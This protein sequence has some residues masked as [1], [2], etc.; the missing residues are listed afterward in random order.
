MTRF[1][2]CAV[3]FRTTPNNRNSR[4]DSL[5]NERASSTDS[6]DLSEWRVQYSARDSTELRTGCWMATS[7]YLGTG[8]IL[9]IIPATSSAHHA[10]LRYPSDISLHCLIQSRGC[11]LA[12]WV[13]TVLRVQSNRVADQARVWGPA[14]TLLNDSCVPGACRPLSRNRIP[15]ITKIF[16]DLPPGTARNIVTA[17]HP[18]IIGMSGPVFRRLHGATTSVPRPT[19]RLGDP[20]RISPGVPTVP[21]QQ[22]IEASA[23]RHNQRVMSK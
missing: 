14:Q 18:R 7:R 17:P 12:T 3:L 4:S 6:C 22:Q 19:S 13:V 5:A 9:T 21:G 15:R 20:T 16:V 10:E 1:D 2:P 23:N 11:V 8:S